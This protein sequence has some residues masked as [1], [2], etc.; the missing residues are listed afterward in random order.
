MNGRVFW[1][2]APTISV[3]FETGVTVGIGGM[4]AGLVAV[5]SVGSSLG[6]AVRSLVDVGVGTGIGASVGVAVGALVNVG[7]AEGVGA[8]VGVGCDVAVPR[9]AAS[10]VA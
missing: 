2:P 1:L 9:T 7:I 5:E 8:A 4:K 10:M 3:V 6:G